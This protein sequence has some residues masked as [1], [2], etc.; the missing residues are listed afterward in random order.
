MRRAWWAI[1]AVCWSTCAL[2]QS[3]ADLVRLRIREFDAGLAAAHPRLLLKPADVPALRSMLL[4]S[5][6]DPEMAALLRQAMPPA[7]PRPLIAEPA[8]VRNGTPEGTRKWQDGY[9]AASEAGSMAQREALA[10]LVTQDPARGREAARWLMSLAAWKI[11][12]EV[13]R[14]NDELFIQHL[15]PMI[16]AYDWAQDALTPAEHETV[17]TALVERLTL[18]AAH[19]EPKFPLQR[20]TPPDNSLSHPMRF[21]STLG[22][23]GL[24][25]YRETP[26]AAQWL[27]WSY[28]YYLRQFPVWGGPAGGWAEGLNYWSTGI[29]QHQR[30]LECMALQGFDAPLRRPFW[31][32]TPYFAI[33]GLMPYAGSSFGDL[34]DGLGPTGSIALMLEKAA[35]L[36]A[37]P[38]PL[39]YA[40]LLRQKPPGGF[41][42]YTYDP[43]DALLQRLRTKLNHLPEVSLAALPQS[44]Y[45]DDIGVVTMHSA[46]GDAADD[47][48]LGFRS[49]PQGSASHGFADQNSF[50]VNAYGQPLAI[51]SGYREYYDSAHHIGWT[52][53]TKS[54]NAVLFGGEGQ[55]IKDA[56]AVGRITRYVDATNFTFA[57]GDARSA[58]APLATRALRHVFFINR[59]YFIVFDE[60]A[61]PSPVSFQWLLHAREKME[62]QAAANEITQQKGDARLTVR[63]LL[64]AVGQ[65]GFTQTD[66]FD[67]PVLPEYRKKM[68][69]EWHVTAQTKLP[70]SAQD[71]IALLYPWRVGD[72]APRPLSQALAADSGH[73]VRVLADEGNTLILLAR[74]NEMQVRTRRWSLEGMAAAIEERTDHVLHL[75]L[76]QIRALDGRI[77]VHASQPFSGEAM[78]DTQGLSLQGQLDASLS[79]Q[80]APG[81]PVRSVEGAADWR[82][83]ADGSITLQL[84]AGAFRIHLM[85]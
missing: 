69:K 45:F 84:A 6:T 2:A 17:R 13:L 49:S 19:V 41:S 85:R 3:D 58:Y 54:K 34:S 68:P 33:Y 70:A 52:R 50:V 8:A 36:N 39:A 71:F 56:T 21:I 78:L 55:R 12:R 51:N 64:P 29:T 59:R 81:F 47:I 30:F 75:S 10:W 61:S 1:I 38:Y 15:R 74:E 43:I 5:G 11:D 63:L 57:S 83:E 32:N 26:D 37:D 24:A 62:L 73:A 14:T 48:M 80:L 46:L 79:L 82:T 77:H 18:L 7:E 9:K 23:G 31:R 65:L 66:A 27:A 53:Q 28:E 60:L 72:R 40:R 16:F 22:L 67:P 35:I 42:Y 25:L 4:A 20:P 44:R 76:V